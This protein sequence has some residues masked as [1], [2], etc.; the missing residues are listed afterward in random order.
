V[1]SGDVDMKVEK[2]KATPEDSAQQASW[3]SVG[4]S[5]TLVTKDLHPPKPMNLMLAVIERENMLKATQQVI[6]NG[7]VAGVDKMSVSELH[8][9]LRVEWPRIR[10]ELLEDRYQPQP[11]K[12][13]EI[14]K[15]GGGQRKLGIPTVLD[16]V[17][18]QAI[19]QVLSPLFEPT[20]SDSS[21]G[22]RPGR[23]AHQAVQAAQVF[24]REGRRWE[25]DMDLEKFFDNVNHDILMV[26]LAKRIEDKILLR[27]IR[28]YLRTPVLV[29]G[30]E[31][32][33]TIGTP[34]GGPLSPLLSN[35]LLTD[36]DRELER[37]GHKFA[38]YA[39][40]C[41]IY[42]QSRAAGDRVLQSISSY[43]EKTLK[44]KV[45]P[46]KSAV[47]RPWN[48]K[49]LGYSLTWHKK[50]KLKVSKEAL[51]R[52]KG[53]VRS[54]F[55]LGRGRNLK[56]FIIDDLNPLLRGWINYFSLAE[57]KVVFEDLDKWLRHKLR[58][59]LWRQWKR[60]WTRFKRLCAAGILP[61]RARESSSNGRG[62]WW[63]S[64]ASHM[65]EAFKNGYFVR[66]GLVSLLAE[67][68]RFRL[69]K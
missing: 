45:N 51:E 18:Q 46:G 37:R 56:S 27:L 23:S 48:R 6:A 43:L 65:N 61:D 5:S 11:I 59:L 19:H 49:F 62:P 52:F 32:M 42:V 9:F 3:S 38:R 14:P 69:L 68:L 7:G 28:R 24:V 63:N 16:R 12:R 47:D 26:R 8:S 57:V 36:L 31:E 50:P 4:A 22:F 64:N 17:I 54:L 35:I 55:R 15:P 29:N 2:P 10:R 58:C 21:Y 60:P 44:L 33:V 40:D 1:E 39:D 53:K 13:V 30:S 41:N 25:V 66:L 67:N 20:F 34:Q